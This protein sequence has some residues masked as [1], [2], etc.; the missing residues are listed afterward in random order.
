MA[1]SG[2]EAQARGPP[3]FPAAGGSEKRRF[4]CK[5]LPER[6]CLKKNNKIS[7]VKMTDLGSTTAASSLKEERNG[8]VGVCWTDFQ[9]R[10]AVVQRTCSALPGFRCSK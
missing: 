8:Q 9:L 3:S 1:E 6:F 4:V 5:Y 10:I 2:R 7:I